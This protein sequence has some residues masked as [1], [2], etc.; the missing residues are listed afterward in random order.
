[1]AGDL[2]GLWVDATAAHSVVPW[3]LVTVASW[4]ALTVASKADPMAGV[5][6]VSKGHWTVVCL[7]IPRVVSKV[8]SRADTLVASMADSLAVSLVVAKVDSKVVSK[9]VPTDD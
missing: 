8:R 6:A 9:A 5:M 7:E 2:V 4:V 1:M 3:V